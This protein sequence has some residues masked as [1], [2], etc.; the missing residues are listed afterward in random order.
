[1]RLQNQFSSH[2]YYITTDLSHRIAMWRHGLR[3]SLQ[4]K[5]RDPNFRIGGFP[6]IQRFFLSWAQCWRQTTLEEHALQ[7]LTINQLVYD[8]CLFCFISMVQDEMRCNSLLSIFL[9]STRHLVYWG[10]WSNG[11]LISTHLFRVMIHW[12][13][14]QSLCWDLQGY[15]TQTMDFLR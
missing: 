12:N 5:G 15:E 11:R 7:L 9:N 4:A 6:L 10:R 1:M 13:V 8:E 3:L 14:M 2:N